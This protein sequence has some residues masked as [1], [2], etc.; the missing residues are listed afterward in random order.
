MGEEAWLRRPPIRALLERSLA[1]LQ[2]EGIAGWWQRAREYA[3]RRYLLRRQRTT[4]QRLHKRWYARHRGTVSIVIP[5]YNDH[6]LLRRCLRSLLRTTDPSR[7]HI[8]ISDDASPSPDH[9]EFLRTLRHPN[10]HVVRR[11]VNG[12]F[13]RAVNTGIQATPPGSDVILLN[14][15]TEALDGWLEALLYAAS[16]HDQVGIVG[17]RLL[18][19]DGTIQSAGTFRHPLQPDWFDH[20]YRFQPTF[21]GPANVPSYVFATTGA[22]MLIRR[23]VLDTVG[24]LDEAYPMAFEDVDFCLRAVQA[25]FRVLYYPHA[26]LIHHE[27]ATR[28]RGVGPRELAAKDLFWRRWR[29]WFDS[30]QV[31]DTSGRARIIYVARTPIDAASAAI[32]GEHLDRLG[33]LGHNTELYALDEAPEHPPLRAPVR[34]FRDVDSLVDEL[35]RQDAIKVATCWRTAEPVWLASLRRGIPAYCVMGTD[36]GTRAGDYSAQ[37]LA[38]SRY[39]REFHYLAISSHQR[40]RLRALGLDAC[41]VGRGVALDTFHVL[42]DARREDD[43]LLTV[44]RSDAGVNFELTLQGWRQLVGQRPRLWAYGP[45]PGAVA[46][47]PGAQYFTPASGP[48]LNRLL[49]R[50]TAFITTATDGSATASILQAMAAGTPVICTTPGLDDEG[51]VAKDSCLVVNPDPASLA[52]AIQQLFSDAGLRER[53]RRAGLETAERRSWHRVIRGVAA[54]YESVGTRYCPTSERGA[55]TVSAPTGDDH[56]AR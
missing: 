27:S 2:Q 7:T 45:Q 22:C 34:V 42:P 13:A 25:G 6:H 3:I 39:R 46:D 26:M 43:V 11:E 49:N 19:P 1:I 52:A 48:E 56:E 40:A 32:I 53:L 20:Y 14:S 54:F 38:L 50:V 51:D 10:V 36:D 29:A 35:S 44:G 30:R 9:G 24:T 55:G 5:S 12:G 16:E 15:D 17:A 4:Q 37:D 31:E 41:H 21:F 18:Y 47:V 23:S 8:V 33:E 28:G